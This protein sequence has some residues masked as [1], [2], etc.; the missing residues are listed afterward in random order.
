M[1][2]LG[3]ERQKWVASQSPGQML[4]IKMLAGLVP[5]EAYLIGS[6]T[7]VSPR[8]LFTWFSSM[9][10]CPCVKCP[11]LRRTPVIQDEV[12]PRGPRSNSITSVA[13]PSPSKVTFRGLF[14]EGTLQPIAPRIP[15]R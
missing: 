3:L 10:A 9:S 1:S 4:G 12:P 2:L 6:R 7:A 15:E 14:L 13:T 8:C 5:P 11:L